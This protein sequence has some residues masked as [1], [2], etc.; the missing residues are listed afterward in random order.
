MTTPPP[1]PE[2]PSSEGTSSSSYIDESGRKRW[3]TVQVSEAK[4]NN[5]WSE[6]PS[7]SFDPNAVHVIHDLDKPSESRLATSTHIVSVDWS[8][9]KGVWTTEDG[10]ELFFV[11]LE[12]GVVALKG[13]LT[14]AS[15]IFAN[16]LA[17]VAGLEDVPKMRVVVEQDSEWGQ[18]TE[19]L[20]RMEATKREAGLKNEESNS[21]LA[22]SLLGRVSF[23]MMEFVR[24]HDLQ[25]LLGEEEGKLIRRIFA[26]REVLEAIGHLIAFDLYVNNWDRFPYVWMNNGNPKNVMFNIRKE[27]VL[28]IDHTFTSIDPEQFG[29]NCE[30]Y[31]QSVQ[32][33]IEEAAAHPDKES[34][35]T[36]RVRDFLLE[37][38][39]VDIGEDG[40]K[41]IQRGLLKGVS[42]IGSLDLDQIYQQQRE[43]K[44]DILPTAKANDIPA[45]ATGITRINRN[46]IEKIH[47]IFSSTAN[48]SIS[49]PHL[50][51]L[52][53]VSMDPR[54]S[55]SRLDRCLCVHRRGCEEITFT[56]KGFLQETSTEDETEETM[57]DAKEE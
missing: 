37:H 17:I 11:E 36:K 6:D 24:G 29:E 10:S 3:E 51:L 25:S 5:V 27:K 55:H 1:A 57:R 4:N 48:R 33:A 7:W 47:A 52:A 23:I 18:M 40:S 20:W 43:V 42:M 34:S 35:Q 12:A 45:E 44:H 39:K 2:L 50:S 49:L 22:K 15:D 19:N 54:R 13:S 26:K 28:G 21:K 8:T 16:N 56:F 9:I 31:L 53:G 38:S 30:K 41:V 32:E 46:F 14:I